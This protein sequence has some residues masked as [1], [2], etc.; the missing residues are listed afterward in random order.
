MAGTGETNG[1]LG[2]HRASYDRFIG[3]VKFGALATAII[4]MLVVFLITR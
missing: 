3:W 4:V 1:D 2:A